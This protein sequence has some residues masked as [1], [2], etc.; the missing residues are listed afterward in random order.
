MTLKK[1]ERETVQPL[2][3]VTECEISTEITLKSKKTRRVFIEGRLRILVDD[4]SELDVDDNDDENNASTTLI[5]VPGVQVWLIV[6]PGVQVFG[7]DAYNRLVPPMT[8]LNK[9]KRKFGISELVGTVE[10]LG[11]PVINHCR[12]CTVVR[13]WC[14]CISLALIPNSPIYGHVQKRMNH[15]IIQC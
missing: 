1:V 4:E 15:C 11:T 10:P 7:L 6:V 14:S 2:A 8:Y 12:K 13:K 3:Q 9:S 5:A